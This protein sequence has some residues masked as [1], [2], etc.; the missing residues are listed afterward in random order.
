MT[1]TCT[2]LIYR[3]N[4]EGGLSEGRQAGSSSFKHS[5][6]DPSYAT[7]AFLFHLP[8]PNAQFS[9]GLILSLE[10]RAIILGK[11]RFDRVRF[12]VYLHGLL[13]GCTQSGNL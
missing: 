12:L 4:D 7:Q 6:A 8:G 13:R 11:C 5:A 1:D 2:F 9:Q 3:W 10:I